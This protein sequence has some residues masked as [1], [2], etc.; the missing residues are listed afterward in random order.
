MVPLVP[1]ATEAAELRL[2]RLITS[3]HTDDVAMLWADSCRVGPQR[4]SCVYSPVRC[5][6]KNR[7]TKGTSS[8]PLP[9]LQSRSTL[10][11]L[12]VA[13]AH[14][15]PSPLIASVRSWHSPGVMCTCP[16]VIRARVRVSA[17]NKLWRVAVCWVADE[18]NSYGQCTFTYLTGCF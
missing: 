9:C 16:P 15:S 2:P 10:Y 4:T 17:S 5:N 3:A 13:L 12:P 1:A 18:V 7:C 6:D 14:V 8:R 11:P